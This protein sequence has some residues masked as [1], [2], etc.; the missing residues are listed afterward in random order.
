MHVAA[1]TEAPLE[2]ISKLVKKGFDVDEQSEE[3]QGVSG[4]YIGFVNSA[5]YGNWINMLSGNLDTCPSLES[6][7]LLPGVKFFMESI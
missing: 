6:L 5:S 1:Q 7:L 2:I 4:L 3:G